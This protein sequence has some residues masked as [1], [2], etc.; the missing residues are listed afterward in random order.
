VLTVFD[1]AGWKSV[2]RNYKVTSKITNLE[3]AYWGIMALPVLN[4]IGG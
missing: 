1:E 2:A 4:D 3:N